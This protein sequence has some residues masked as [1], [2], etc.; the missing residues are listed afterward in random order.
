MRW[1][2]MG[3]N[4]YP[5]LQE[6]L[7]NLDKDADSRKAAM[8]ALKSFVKD[9][10]SKEIPLFIAE[11]SQKIEA[12]SLSGEC[13]ISLYEVL[14]RV[15]GAKIVPL[16]ETIMKTIINTLV[17]SAG[18]FPL[19]QACSKVVMAIAR[20]GIDPNFNEEKKRH[21]I[22]SLC[23][24]L[25]D[26]LLGSQECLTSGAALCLKALVENDS[27]RFS[28]YEMVNKVCQ[29][30][31][32]ALVENSTQ[33]NAH[34]GLVSALAKR[35]AVA[36]E[37]YARLLIQSGLRIVNAGIEQGNSQKRLSAI[38]MVNILM[39][40]LDSWSICSELQWIILE[41]E[42]CQSDRMAFVKGAAS[43]A[44]QTARRI[45]AGKGLNF[46]KGP[47]LVTGP[48]FRVGNNDKKKFILNAGDQATVSPGPQI[49]NSFPEYDS[50]IDS[51]I[52]STEDIQYLDS[53]SS[54]ADKMLWNYDNGGV[55]VS[56]KDGFFS[57]IA[58]ASGISNTKSDEQPTANKFADNK[59]NFDKEFLG[60]SQSIPSN[61]ISSGATSSPLTPHTPINVDNNNIFKTPKKLVH[62]FQDPIKVNSVCSENQA[63]S[64]RNHSLDDFEWSSDCRCDHNYI[65]HDDYD[66]RDDEKLYADVDQVL[67]GS[68][69]VSSTEDFPTDADLQVSLKVV[70]ENKTGHPK[71]VLK[72]VCGLSFAAM[73][74]FTPLIW[75]NHQDEVGYLVPT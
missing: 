25:S 71:L 52:L 26:S 61:R 37:P 32:G 22:H 34:M 15:H 17:S 53:D 69:S 11:V 8:R 68:E 67:E 39:K 29:N 6:E 24:P 56:L 48:N 45:A 72:L 42:K 18:C 9:L 75:L 33:T 66:Y 49:F 12:G 46:D 5:L 73:A 43:E 64:S 50:L 36:V 30:V 35:N 60:F 10:D 74:I 47:D 4:L 70:A 20:Y 31:A 38:Q 59:E 28:S 21:V 23:N 51:P 40:C 14:A 54:G 65:S 27:W 58:K 7:K 19:Q 63:R 62:S 16:I 55:D 13:T 2:T 44:L 41:M 3:R 1:S 57:G